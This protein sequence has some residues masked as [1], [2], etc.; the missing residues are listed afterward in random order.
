[1]YSVVYWILWVMAALPLGLAKIV[2]VL[3]QLAL[4]YC[5]T[6]KTEDF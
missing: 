3:A 2:S 4:M 6:L 1:M 5:H